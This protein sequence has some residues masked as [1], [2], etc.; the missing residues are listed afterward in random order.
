MVR[1]KSTA[2]GGLSGQP[3]TRANRRPAQFSVARTFLNAAAP[4]FNLSAS[5]AIVSLAA[6]QMRCQR[7]RYHPEC[8]CKPLSNCGQGW[9]PQVIDSANS[10]VVAH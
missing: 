6:A 2:I 7:N 5:L 10:M 3:N 9:F 4:I 8:H 1:R